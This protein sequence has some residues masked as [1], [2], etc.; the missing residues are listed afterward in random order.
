M[1]KVRIVGGGLTGIIAALQA[2]RLGCRDIELFE[3]YGELG[4]SLLPRTDHGLELRQ[5]KQYF[6]GRGDPLRAL[7]EWH[8]VAFE[9]FE[10]RCGSVSPGPGGEP[11]Y[12]EAF[13][14][15]SLAARQTALVE[16]AGESLADRL[17]AYPHDI[18]QALSKYCQ[19]NLGVWLD[20]VHE[21]SAAPLGLGRV[22]PRATDTTTLAE[23]KRADDLYDALYG[24]PRHL[25]GR[26]QGSQASLPK[27]GFPAL[28]AAAG[29]ALAGL[30][31]KIHLESLISPREA[32]AACRPGEALVWAA[33]PGALYKAAGVAAPKPLVKSGATYVFKA[34]TDLKPFWL[35]NFTAQGVVFRI[36]TY[37][38]RGETLLTAE[39]VA[40]AG[41]AELRREIRKLMSGF[42]AVQLK[43]Q[44]L[45]AVEPRHGL[46]SMAEAKALK[47]LDA[48]LSQ[49][50]GG[51][52]VPGCWRAERIEDAFGRIET[53]LA[54]ALTPEQAARTA[55]AA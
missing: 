32:L 13:G 43:D 49:T 2:H 28:F 7:L 46:T 6:G 20:E 39:C 10:D 19:W 9:D 37:E 5:T 48:K 42:G 26:T 23:L 33:G 11:V 16:P 50:L 36:S 24:L 14:G 34:K 4:G 12:A 38:S 27:G 1:G 8:G 55:S 17:R 3:Q 40:E 30:G 54:G 47:A 18:E 45:A 41:D 29:R 25:W 53:A 31:V 35:Q 22:H 15:P 51:A 52:F 44:L 21:S